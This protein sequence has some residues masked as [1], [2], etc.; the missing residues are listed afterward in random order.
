MT[1]SNQRTDDGPPS[2]VRRLRFRI[3]TLL[4]LVLLFAVGL[5]AYIQYRAPRTPWERAGGMIGWSQTAIES[6]LGSPDEVVDGD[7]PDPHAQRSRLRLP[8][9]YRTFVYRTFDGRF[10]VWMRDAAD[11]SFECF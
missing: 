10:V 3:T 2:R 5:S 7:A 11:G 1:D 6:E 8:G 9:T 4:G